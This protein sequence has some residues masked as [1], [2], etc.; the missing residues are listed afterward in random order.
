MKNEVVFKRNA[1]TTKKKKVRSERL[2]AGQANLIF[3]I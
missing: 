2:K 1:I 3:S